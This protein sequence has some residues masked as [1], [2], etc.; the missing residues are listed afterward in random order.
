MVELNYLEQV[1]L[2]GFNYDNCIRNTALEA[3]VKTSNKLS[4]TKTGTTICGVVFNVS[5]GSRSLS[6]LLQSRKVTLLFLICFRV[7]LHLL[8]IRVPQPA[9]S[10]PIRTVRS[11]T[12]WH[13]TSTALVLVQLLIVTMSLV[14]QQNLANSL[15][16]F[17][18]VRS[19]ASLILTKILCLC[20][21]DD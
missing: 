3:N 2:G 16:L 13:L 18:F 11:F 1:P 14:S 5:N 17:H 9:P 21:R 7:V 12:S 19:R 20:C 10:S 6:P 15:L 8:L 4:Y